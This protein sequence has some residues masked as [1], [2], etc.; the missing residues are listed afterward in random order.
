M[1]R[2]RVNVL[3][4]VGALLAVISVF[5]T[6]ITL[7]FFVWTR[8]MNLIDVYNQVESSSDFWLPAIL[9]LM[10]TLVAFLTPLGGIMQAI[11][12][13]LFMSAFASLADGRLPS[14]IGPY[15]GLAAAA[16]VL[17]SLAYPVGVGYSAK[18]RGIL[19]RVLTVSPIGKEG[20]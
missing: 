20:P 19:G 12:A 8:E 9:F 7:G 13:P 5:S 3:C 1:A 14:G 15:L 4:L 11:G 10:G 2:V 18:S 6:W 17:A 16:I